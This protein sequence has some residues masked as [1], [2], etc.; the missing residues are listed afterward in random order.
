MHGWSIRLPWP[1]KVVLLKS[2]ARLPLYS[3]RNGLG[4]RVVRLLGG[5]RITIRDRTP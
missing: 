2:P 1:G 3:E 4:V 5:W